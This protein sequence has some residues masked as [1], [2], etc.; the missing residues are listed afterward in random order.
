LLPQ[1]QR[2]TA[3][4]SFVNSLKRINMLVTEKMYGRPSDSFKISICTSFQK[5]KYSITQ[6]SGKVIS[7]GAYASSDGEIY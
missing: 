1:A 6:S 2:Y 5:N 3:I 4:A 7:A